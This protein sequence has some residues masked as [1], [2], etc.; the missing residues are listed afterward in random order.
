MD[1]WMLLATEE[2]DSAFSDARL[3][4]KLLEVFHDAG[5]TAYPCRHRGLI[6]LS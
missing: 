1:R 3:N 5:Q 2:E 6:G 4:G